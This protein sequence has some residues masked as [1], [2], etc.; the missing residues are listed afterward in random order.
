MST[1]MAPLILVADDEADIALVTSARLEAA[2]YR[3]LTAPD[4]EA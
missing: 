1:E 3:V 2:G 4:G